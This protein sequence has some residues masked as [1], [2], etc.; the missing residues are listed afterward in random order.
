MHERRAIFIQLPFQDRKVRL[1]RCRVGKHDRQPAAKQAHALEPTWGTVP[2]V[3]ERGR[4]IVFVDDVAQDGVGVVNLEKLPMLSLDLLHA[5][6]GP[7]WGNVLPKWVQH[8][9]QEDAMTQ[10]D[11]LSGQHMRHVL[12]QRAIVAVSLS[13]D[14][15]QLSDQRHH[16]RG[17]V[18]DHVLL[19]SCFKALVALT[20]ERALIFDV[21]D[22][23]HG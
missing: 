21:V 3:I 6:L 2:R 10:L 20:C 13:F 17:D 8:I 7:E 14:R 11:H 16:V 4:V 19:I 12:V 22:N 9:L 5:L 18:I 15:L 23:R 1:D